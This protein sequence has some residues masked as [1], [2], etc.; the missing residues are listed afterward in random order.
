MDIAQRIGLDHVA[1][2]R[3]GAV[4]LDEVD[5]F[6][7]DSGERARAHELNLRA[8]VGRGD[9][10]AAPIVVGSRAFHHR[11]DGLA[12]GNRIVEAA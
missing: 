10:V 8:S 9:P 6:R 5:V 1:E 4:C 3:A 7:V 11:I 2:E 12:G